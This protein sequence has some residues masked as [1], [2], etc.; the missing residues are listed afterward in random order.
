M[1]YPQLFYY[2]LNPTAKLDVTTEIEHELESL[3]YPLNYIDFLDVCELGTALLDRR[4]LLKLES[5]AAVW[6]EQIHQVQTQNTSDVQPDFAQL[7]PVQHRYHSSGMTVEWLAYLKQLLTQIDLSKLLP[8]LVE[9]SQEL[10]PKIATDLKKL[11]KNIREGRSLA[12]LPPSTLEF[13]ALLSTSLLM[14][15][16]ITPDIVFAKGFSNSGSSYRSYDT[17]RYYRSSHRDADCIPDPNYPGNCD[18]ISAWKIL[19]FLI[20]ALGGIWLYNLISKYASD[21]E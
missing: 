10:P 4:D 17:N 21:D 3:D 13:I 2:L 20:T 5:F 8:R 6:L 9:R 16:L 1:N 12:A 18:P 14:A 7:V 15:N 19:G 11:A